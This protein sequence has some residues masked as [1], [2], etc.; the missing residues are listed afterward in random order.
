M[1]QMCSNDINCLWGDEQY[2]VAKQAQ[3]VQGKQTGESR[4]V[5]RAR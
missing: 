1:L 3:Q 5:F 4:D 2:L